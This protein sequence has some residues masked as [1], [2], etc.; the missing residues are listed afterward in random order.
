MKITILG[1]GGAGGVPSIARGWGLCD[2]ENPR[3]RRLR[4]S[5]WMQVDGVSILID[6][7]PD[8]RQQI[9]THQIEKI[10]AILVTHAHF[11]HCHGLGELREMNLKMRAP[12]PVFAAPEVI[13]ELIKSFGYCFEEIE[14]EEKFFKPKL[15]PHVVSGPFEA[16]GVGVIPI[17]QDHGMSISW[18]FRIGG[19]AYC[20]DV[21]R[22]DETARAQLQ[23]L[24]LWVVDCYTDKPHPTHIHFPGV[25][26]WV[27]DLNP[28]RTV[29]TAMGHTIDYQQTKA[30]CP[31]G[32]EPGYDGMVIGL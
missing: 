18:G 27:V 16:L 3:N 5:V 2:P 13:E 8:V 7:G 21:V 9:L 11:D 26:E 15:I 22:L 10:D 30:A 23:D 12:I 25:L 19:F 1:C 14:N 20:P 4:S 28:K 17:R 31:A 6:P 24:D 29:L 32:V